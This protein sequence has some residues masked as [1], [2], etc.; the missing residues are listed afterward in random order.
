MMDVER[1]FRSGL[2]GRFKILP[3]RAKVL[4][5]PVEMNMALPTCSFAMLRTVRRKA[6]ESASGELDLCRDFHF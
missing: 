4:K 3:E 5:S 6:F 2:E 1:V